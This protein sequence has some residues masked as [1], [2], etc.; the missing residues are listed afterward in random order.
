MKYN[1]FI[2]KTKSSLFVKFQ[3][4]PRLF[5]DVLFFRQH[6]PAGLADIL[7]QP[8]FFSK[9]FW[10]YGYLSVWYCL[11]EAVESCVG[12]QWAHSQSL[13]TQPDAYHRKQMLGSRVPE[14]EF[15][16]RCHA[17]PWWKFELQNMIMRLAYVI[18]INPLTYLLSFNINGI[19]AVFFYQNTIWAPICN[20]NSFQ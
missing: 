19:S 1:Y 2:I 6:L 3:L 18:C 10:S 20:I 11:L 5:G 8:Y 13:P 9:L 12:E 7:R 17:L 4:T 15:I 16:P 14:I